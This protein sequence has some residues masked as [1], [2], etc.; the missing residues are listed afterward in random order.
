M[1]KTLVAS[2]ALVLFAGSAMAVPVDMTTTDDA[3]LKPGAANLGDATQVCVAGGR[4]LNAAMIM[5]FDL[6]GYAGMTA[7]GDGTL[8]IRRGWDQNWEELPTVLRELTGGTFDEMTVSW[9]SYVGAAETTLAS[10]MGAQIAVVH[11]P[12]TYDIWTIDVPQAT[13]QAMVDGTV[14]GLML[15]NVDGEYVNSCWGTKERVGTG[16]PAYGPEHAPVL[17]CELVP[18]PA[19]MALLGLG[20]LVALR[21]RR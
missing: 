6:T 4:D 21:R 18:E 17:H 8:T 10:V 7:A 2:L 15:T 12:S 11:A 19:T 14:Q 3:F 1:N 20:G 13:L 5:E 9:D 16:D